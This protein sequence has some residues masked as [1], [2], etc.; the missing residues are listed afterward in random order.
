MIGE[1]IKMSRNI[2]ASLIQMA[3]DL[4]DMNLIKYADEITQVAEKIAANSPNDELLEN[5]QNQKTQE[6]KN[7][8]ELQETVDKTQ[9]KTIPEIN[10]S[11]A[12]ARRRKMLEEKQQLQ[13]SEQLIQTPTPQIFN[14]SIPM[15]I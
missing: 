6:E 3:N 13:N 1:M 4:D 7:L 11:M 10:R 14:P 8:K 9:G 2:V 5:L 15:N 12:E